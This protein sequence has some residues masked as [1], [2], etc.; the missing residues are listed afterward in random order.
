MGGFTDWAEVSPVG[1]LLVRAARIAGDR[2]A[3]VFPDRR[4]TYAE[5]LDGAV[6]VARGLL[7]AR[8]PA[9]PACRA[10]DEQLRRIRAWFFWHRP[11]WMRGRTLECTS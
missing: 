4:V 6:E 11:G 3:L 9:L 2:D 5:L 1:D 8:H 10:S 7:G